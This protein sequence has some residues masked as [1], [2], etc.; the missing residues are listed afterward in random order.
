MWFPVSTI[1]AV[2]V[3]IDVSDGMRSENDLELVFKERTHSDWRNAWHQEK[4][5]RCRGD[6]V[7]HLFWACEKDIYRLTRRSDPRYKSYDDYDND[8]I[9]VDFPWK[10][11]RR[12]KRILRFRRSIDRRSGSSITNECCKSTGCTWEEYAEYCPT[13][14][15]YTSYV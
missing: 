3:L 4:H 13:N 1:A 14:K 15:R 6:L 9:E 7:K 11:P 10:S 2:C 12:A 5:S 8:D